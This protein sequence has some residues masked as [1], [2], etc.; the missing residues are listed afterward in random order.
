MSGKPSFLSKFIIILSTAVF[1][2][3]F[4]LS[5]FSSVFAQTDEERLKAELERIE[6]E[7]KQTESTLNQQKQQTTTI[8]GKVNQLGTEI[9]KAQTV[10]KL[11]NEVI[12]K[13]G[14][15]ISLKEQN[16]FQLNAKLERSKKT[17]AEL[18]R[19]TDH[20][21]DLTLPEIILAYDSLSDFFEAV[22]SL[23]LVQNSLNSLFDQIRELR[24]LTEEEKK[25]LEERKI[26]EADAKKQVEDQKE[27]VAVKK[28]EQDSLLAVSKNTEKS[29]EQVL[30]EKRQKAAAIRSA[31]FKMRDSE[32]ISF[33]QALDYANE[34][35]KATGV[36]PAF[37]LAILKQETDLG[38]NVGTCNRPGDPEEKLWYNIMP[39]PTDGSWRDDQTNFKKITDALGISPEGTPLSCPMGNGWGGA[40]GPSQFIPT[41]WLSYASR[42]QSALGVKVANPWNPEHAFTATALYMSDL[43][44]GTQ[45]Y[46]AEKT[47]ALKYYAGS[48]WSLPQNQFYGNQV[49][50]HADEFQKNID[51]LKDVD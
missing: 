42:I 44:A 33:G 2:F 3:L 51:F 49:M 16:V 7:I 30:A 15:D 38:K 20:Y 8:Q 23:K 13:L 28:N 26:K 27:Q 24:G 48:N 31:L 32:G 34:A 14:S 50:A 9:K 22:D 36:R 45:A 29:Y 41:T 11:K 47:A 10:I 6:Q 19:A 37:I 1:A 25:K 17:L 12:N 46:T 5:S 21:D 4:I 18:L 39:G 40:M 43:G 35:S